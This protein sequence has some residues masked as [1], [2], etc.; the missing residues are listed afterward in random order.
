M[1]CKVVEN[2]M[3]GFIER[4]V[5]FDIQS[6]IEEHLLH[7]GPC[8]FLYDK[9]NSTYSI[10]LE[11]N[12]PEISPYFYSRL[13]QRLLQKSRKKIYFSGIGTVLW[14]PVAASL[15]ILVGIL[16]G[17]SI[18]RH[19]ELPVTSENSTNKSEVINIYATEYYLNG[20]GEDILIDY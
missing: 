6:A 14:Q 17:I 15:I 1:N 10:T 20:T 19:V 7:C 12:I 8:K 3:I 9:V 5:P 16:I 4:Q 13:E 11:K 18:G 2:N